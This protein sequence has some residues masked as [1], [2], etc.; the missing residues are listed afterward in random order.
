MIDSATSKFLEDAEAG[1]SR[2][3]IK[4][5]KGWWAKKGNMISE[6]QYVGDALGKG[7]Q[8]KFAR[9][10]L[11]SMLWFRNFRSLHSGTMVG[12]LGMDTQ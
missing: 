4:V 9:V 1:T 6:N 8:V 3:Y 7:C 2:R 5:P 10:L 12:C 11:L